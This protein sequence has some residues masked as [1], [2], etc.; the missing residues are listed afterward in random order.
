MD[1]VPSKV[2]SEDHCKSTVTSSFRISSSTESTGSSECERILSEF[3]WVHVVAGESII[4][5]STRIDFECDVGTHVLISEIH[6]AELK[7]WGILSRRF[8]HW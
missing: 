1:P 8:P 3:Q 5:V 7:L 2:L 4:D 6:L